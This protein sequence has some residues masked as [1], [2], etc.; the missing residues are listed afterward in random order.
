MSGST[1]AS[2]KEPI[3][4]RIDQCSE[5]RKKADSRALLAPARHQRRSSAMP[6]GNHRDASTG[7]TAIAKIKEEMSI[8]TTA[9]AIEPR[10]SPLAP[11]SSTSGEKAS[12]VVRAEDNSGMR[13]RETAPFIASMGERPARRRLRISS[14]MTIEPSTSNPR[15]TTRPVT[16]I[17]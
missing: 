14:V 9:M 17:C 11:G 7:V 13:M 5:A 8:A 16:D 10:K 12:T 15:A 3:G 6:D 1:S 2:E 4:L